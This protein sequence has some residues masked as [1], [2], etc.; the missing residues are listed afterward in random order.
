MSKLLTDEDQKQL[1][2]VAELV[3]QGDRSGVFARLG[4][5]T[6][7]LASGIP[8][9]GKLGEE[10]LRTLFNQSAYGGMKTALAEL[11]EESTR[12]EAAQLVA[13]HIVAQLKGCLAAEDETPAVQAAQAEL[14]ARLK[15][16]LAELGHHEIRIDTVQSASTGI[17]AE[18][19]ADRMKAE[20]KRVTGRGT[21]GVHLK[22]R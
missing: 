10:G 22:G 12:H 5:L 20:I 7:R 17:V 14:D 18:A 21:I 16:V 9:L 3:R 11:G 2:E 13:R 1:G 4:N 6:L 8:L 15:Q 19:G